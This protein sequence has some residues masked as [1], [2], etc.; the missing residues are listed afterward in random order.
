MGADWVNAYIISE[1]LYTDSEHETF[2]QVL[3]EQ[4]QDG[5]Y[6][7]FPTLNEFQGDER[8]SYFQLK[9]TT[10]NDIPT[11]WAEVIY[12]NNKDTEYLK[13]LLTHLKEHNW[14]GKFILQS[15]WRAY[16]YKLATDIPITEDSKLEGEPWLVEQSQLVLNSGLYYVIAR[17]GEIFGPYMPDTHELVQICIDALTNDVIQI[18]QPAARHY[19]FLYITDVSRFVQKLIDWMPEN[20]H[21]VFNVSYGTEYKVPNI[22]KSIRHLVKSESPIQFVKNEGMYSK[23]TRSVGYHCQMN[24]DKVRDPKGFDFAIITDPLRGILQLSRWIE[25]LIPVDNRLQQSLEQV[26]PSLREDFWKGHDAS[27]ASD[28]PPDHVH[29]FVPV[30]EDEDEDEQ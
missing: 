16:G 10:I 30:D 25:S 23:P 12:F 13:N 29:E 9:E 5:F 22:A 26:Y 6:E 4:N 3:G 28:I 17:Y 14:K 18:E 15:S 20:V 7:L 27:Q 8:L 1:I 11:D 24:V 2:I 19:D 21:E